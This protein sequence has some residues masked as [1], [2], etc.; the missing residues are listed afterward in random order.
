MISAVPR[1]LSPSSVPVWRLAAAAGVLWCWTAGAFAQS[2]YGGP[3][4]NGTG[5]GGNATPES[6]VQVLFWCAVLLGAA[7]ALGLAFFILRK[8]LASA[9]DDS[10]SAVNPMGFTLADLRQ[11]HA[12]GQLSDE[13]FDFSKRK[14]MARA[15]AQL[16]GPPA[17]DEEPEFIDLGDGTEP[18]EAESDADE[19]G[20][21]DDPER[22]PA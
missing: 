13:E 4:A 19:Q 6:M 21:P 18:P 8:K 1:L 3:P 5:G 11:M 20:P 2:G 16:E 15:K 22:P 10:A 14:M 7:V 17:E 9:D 12:D